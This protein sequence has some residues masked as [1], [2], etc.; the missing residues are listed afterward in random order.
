MMEKKVESVD[1]IIGKSVAA[2]AQ[3][4]Q[5]QNDAQWKERS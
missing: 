1:A 2:P 3:P 4:V 5:A